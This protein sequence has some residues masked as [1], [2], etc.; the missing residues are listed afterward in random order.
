VSDSRQKAYR[1]GQFGEFLCHL[2]L[3][4]SGYRIVAK[5]Y[6]TP[7]G[8]IDL[9]A[10][11][12]RHGTNAVLVFV[13]VKWRKD[14]TSALGAVTQRQRSRVQKSAQWFLTQRPEFQSVDLRFD[15]MLVRPWRLPVH[16]RNAW[17]D[18]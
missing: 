7:V 13:E 6:R 9:I 11:K 18:A 3:L 2:Y 15:V 1:R 10:T 8:E 5:R 4:L 14:L 17:I 12:G 16:I